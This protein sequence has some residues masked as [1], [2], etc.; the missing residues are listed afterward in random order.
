[1]KQDNFALLFSLLDNHCI[2]MIDIQQL[3]YAQLL[4]TTAYLPGK[5][6][7]TEG[8]NKSIGPKSD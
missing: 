1:M 6:L 8:V 4:G 7:H 2:R 5:P 3:Y